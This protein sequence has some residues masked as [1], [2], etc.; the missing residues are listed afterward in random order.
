MAQMTYKLQSEHQQCCAVLLD[1]MHY[2]YAPDVMK[3][4]MSFFLTRNVVYQ[5]CLTLA[6]QEPLGLI[7]KRASPYCNKIF[8]SL[9][10]STDKGE[11]ILPCKNRESIKPH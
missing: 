4:N 9:L 11:T 6:L 5:L 2:I 10:H 3:V 7:V 8:V 1:Q